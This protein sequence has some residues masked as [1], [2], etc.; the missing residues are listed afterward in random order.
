[1]ASAISDGNRGDR[2]GKTPA[3]SWG[4]YGRFELSLL[5]TNCSAIRKLAEELAVQLT[6]LSVAYVDADHK[7]E[8]G[9][10]GRSPFAICYSDKIAFGRIDAKSPDFPLLRKAWFNACDLVLVNG[11]HFSASL[12]IAVIDPKKPLEGKLD[13]LSRPVMVLM[14]EGVGEIPPRV[15]DCL[16]QSGDLPVFGINDVRGIAAA[17]LEL[18]RSRLPSLYGLVLAGGRSER[19]GTDKG[20]IDY[21]GKP[22]REHLFDLLQA[23]CAETFISCRSDQAGQFEGGLPYIADS[24]LGLGQ[25]GAILSAFQRHPD[26]AWLVAACDLPLLGVQSLNQ[27][28]GGRNTGKYATAFHNPESGFTEPLA[29]IW[30]PRSYPALLHFLGMGYSCPRKVLLN[31]DVE[32]LQPGHPEELSNVNSPEELERVKRL[33]GRDFRID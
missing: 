33:L 29:A 1:M 19:M 8:T 27:L 15:A 12:Q 4:E 16:R 28:T 11:N 6:G 7:A 20:L 32:I 13:R 5:G 17:V 10:A 9:N 14:Q 3:A 23:Y 30:E 24:F 31:T 2:H 21:H 18:Y 26:S 25:F 22:Q